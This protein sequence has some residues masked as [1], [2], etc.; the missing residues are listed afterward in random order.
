ML[1]ISLLFKKLP[2]MKNLITVI[3]SCLFY[4]NIYAQSGTPEYS[5]SKNFSFFKK[6]EVKD[7][8]YEII[9]NPGELQYVIR[10]IL[11]KD[12][13]VDKISVPASG[14]EIRRILKNGFDKNILQISLLR[15]SM[16][17]DDNEIVLV[18]FA[19]VKQ[20]KSGKTKLKKMCFVEYSEGIFI[21]RKIRGEDKNLPQ[22][23]IDYLLSNAKRR[24]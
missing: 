21:E 15:E 16:L 5:S 8:F 2:Q 4:Q 1:R 10:L 14:L 7:P 23:A 22:K 24:Q 9:I 6:E 3:L 17:M 13:L 19:I 18:L 12:I 11:S 20:K